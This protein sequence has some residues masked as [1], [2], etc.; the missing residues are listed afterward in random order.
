MPELRDLESS[1][2]ERRQSGNQA[3][4]YAGLANIS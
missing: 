2:V 1:P 3:S 4:Y